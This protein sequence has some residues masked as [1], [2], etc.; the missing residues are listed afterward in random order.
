MEIKEE[1]IPIYYVCFT[2]KDIEYKIEIDRLENFIDFHHRGFTSYTSKGKYEEDTHYSLYEYLCAINIISVS[3]T[4]SVHTIHVYDRE[5]LMKF[6]STC[7]TFLKE[8]KKHIR[9][10]KLDKIIKKVK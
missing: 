3:V 9:K 1:F 8:K 6:F 4:E 2:H 10:I 7:K 5:K